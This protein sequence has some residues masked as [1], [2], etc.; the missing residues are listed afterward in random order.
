MTTKDEFI[1]QTQERW[2]SERYAGVERPYS[3]EDVWRL[4]GSFEIEYSLANINDD[5]TFHVSRN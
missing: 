4:R 3:A 2:A 5:N 1:R